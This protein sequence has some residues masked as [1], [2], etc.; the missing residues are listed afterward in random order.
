MAKGNG[1]TRSE[2]PSTKNQPQTFE[3]QV[4]SALKGL[5]TEFFDRMEDFYDGQWERFQNRYAEWKEKDDYIWGGRSSMSAPELDRREDEAYGG[6]RHRPHY[7]V[8]NE[9]RDDYGDL[10][11][12]GLYKEGAKAPHF[13]DLRKGQANLSDAAKAV[14]AT[15]ERTA[16]RKFADVRSKMLKTTV[17]KGIN[18]SNAR[19][20]SVSGDGFLISDGKVSLHARYIMAWGEIKAPHFRFIITDRK[21]K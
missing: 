3:E 11:V 5:K 4:D 20:E 18:L 6:S 1:N 19:V 7:Q 13:Y 12:G 9:I 14:K 2:G 15:A 10:T 16:E 8:T 21:S 17:E